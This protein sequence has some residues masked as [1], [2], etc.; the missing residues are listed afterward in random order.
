MKIFETGYLKPGRKK[1]Q[2]RSGKG[3]KRKFVFCGYILIQAVH[4]N[5]AR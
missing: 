5:D 4:T 3:K 1:G 2:M